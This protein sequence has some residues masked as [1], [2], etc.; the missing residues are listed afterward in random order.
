METQELT[1]RMSKKLL[2]KIGRLADQ[3]YQSPET[4][5][6][7]ALAH[8]VRQVSM[9]QSQVRAPQMPD[10]ECEPQNGGYL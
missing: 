7:S 4:Y 10:T 9:A 2:A 3:S 6:E 8:L 1:V 5:I